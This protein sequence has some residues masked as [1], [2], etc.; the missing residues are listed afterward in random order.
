MADNLLP[1]DFL[2][3][4]ENYDEDE[5]ENGEEEDT[6]DEE[7]EDSEDDVARQSPYFDFDTGDFPFGKS[8]EMVAASPEEIW[9]QWCIKT[10]ETPRYALEAYSDDIGIDFEEALQSESHEEAENILS[11]EIEE[12]LLADPAGRTLFVGD[13]TFDWEP[14]ACTVTVPVQ[15]IDGETDITVTLKESEVAGYGA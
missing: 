7:D 2:D 12:A 1:E 4:E 10:I 11:R 14:D 3:D 13:I 15:G 9:E 8:G 5:E 6:D